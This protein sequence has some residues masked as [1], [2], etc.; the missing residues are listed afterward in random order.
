[1]AQWVQNLMLPQQQQQ[2]R[3]HLLDHIQSMVWE[4]PYSMGTARKKKKNDYEY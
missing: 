1:M 2:H 3:L 4:R